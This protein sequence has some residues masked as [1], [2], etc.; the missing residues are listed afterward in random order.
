[1]SPKPVG[2][3]DRKAVKSKAEWGTLGPSWVLWH[4][5]RLRAEGGVQGEQAVLALG[6]M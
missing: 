6:R 2:E 4:Q 5:E 1:M 3:S